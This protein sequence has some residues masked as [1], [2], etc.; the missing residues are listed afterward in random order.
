M[1]VG[2]PGREELVGGEEGILPGSLQDGE[3]SLRQGGG[4]GNQ[5]VHIRYDNLLYRA[6]IYPAKIVQFLFPGSP[7]AI[8]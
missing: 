8:D 1:G 6:F 4:A 3:E 5:L 7:S 2:D